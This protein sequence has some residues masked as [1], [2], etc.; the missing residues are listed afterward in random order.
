M[1]FGK[2]FQFWIRSV[3][4]E[5]NL[6]LDVVDIL[7]SLLNNLLIIFGD[8]SNVVIRSYV[9]TRFLVLQYL[10]IAIFLITVFFASKKFNMEKLLLVS[11]PILFLA[12]HLF[13]D[14][15]TEYP[16]HLVAGY[17]SLNF[18]SLILNKETNFL[19]SK[20]KLNSARY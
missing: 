14:G 20:L 19:F 7:S 3:D 18:V 11:I 5:A 6:R 13:F 10:I 8:F 4:V 12:P 9:S 15:V 17:I 2:I 16:K 1:Y